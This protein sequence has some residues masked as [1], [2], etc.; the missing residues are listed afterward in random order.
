MGPII[1]GY[2][3]IVAVYKTQNE[4]EIKVHK[5]DMEQA[6]KLFEL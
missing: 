6:N 1:K 5:I 3:I 2:L 4:E